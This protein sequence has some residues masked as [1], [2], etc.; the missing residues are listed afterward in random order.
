VLSVVFALTA[1]GR[2]L[3][4]NGIDPNGNQQAFRISLT[5]AL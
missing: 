5:T 3:I 2:V 1:D 4:G